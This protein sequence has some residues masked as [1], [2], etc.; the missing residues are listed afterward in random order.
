MG[1]DP[2]YITV[3]EATRILDCEPDKI[4]ELLDDHAIRGRRDGDTAYVRQEDIAELLRL[5]MIGIR[6]P[7]MVKRMLFLETTVSRLQNSINLLFEINN[8][9]AS[10]FTT[11]SD[12][13]LGNLYNTTLSIL[14]EEEWSI[15]RMLQLCEV[16]LKITEVEIYRLNEIL[17]LDNTWLPF[18][19]LAL[20]LTA[21]VGRHDALETSFELQKVRDLLYGGRKNLQTIAILFIEQKAQLGPSRE[22][23]SKMAA[24]DMEA[25]DVLIRQI[26]SPAGPRG[27]RLLK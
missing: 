7:E 14:K 3:T 18:Y 2:V 16:F 1:S 9:S 19:R 20:R 24:T 12:E 10:R 8:L 15:D 13:E 4:Y 27:V 25:F 11:M 6:F 23:L 26:A 21:Y 22:L 5:D 17:S